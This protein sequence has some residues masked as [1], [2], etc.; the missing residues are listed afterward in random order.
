LER[1]ERYLADKPRSKTILKERAKN[2]G[3]DTQF[4]RKAG[5]REGISLVLC[6]I[7]KKRISSA[8]KD[9][10][11]RMKRAG[12]GENASQGKADSGTGSEGKKSL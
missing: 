7:K 8:T 1:L 4:S 6:A 5:L 3:K 12:F 9:E 11:E 2:R 10:L